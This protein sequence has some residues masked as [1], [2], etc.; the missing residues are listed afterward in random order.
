MA[1]C[2][3]PILVGVVL[4]AGAAACTSDER[5]DHASITVSPAIAPMD[6]P[7]RVSVAGLRADHPATVTATA[8]DVVGVTWSSSAQFRAGGDGTLSL[9]QAPV[10]GSYSGANP[11]GLF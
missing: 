4:A 11:M 5:V 9:D 6:Q 2:A 10:G 3:V 1:R 7:V 8:K